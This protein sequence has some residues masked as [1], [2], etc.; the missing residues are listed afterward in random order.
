[1]IKGYNASIVDNE[2]RTRKAYKR[3]RRE[4]CKDKKCIECEYHKVCEEG[5]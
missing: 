3:R 1:M 4:K 2:Y 5:E